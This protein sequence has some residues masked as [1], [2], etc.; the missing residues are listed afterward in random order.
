MLK[1][2]FFIL[3]CKEVIYEGSDTDL[4]RNYI[5]EFAQQFH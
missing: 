1:G 3:E 4:K 2:K 5:T